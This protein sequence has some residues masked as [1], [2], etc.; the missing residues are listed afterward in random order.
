M[1]APSRSLS[2]TK[3]RASDTKEK[4]FASS[5]VRRRR[6]QHKEDV[7]SKANYIFFTRLNF[8]LQ[9]L[10][11]HFQLMS[12]RVSGDVRRQ[13]DVQGAGN[14]GGWKL[15]LNSLKLVKKN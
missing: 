13:S 8:L 9:Q 7:M 15:F 10:Y 6:P 2:R 12:R 14:L 5:K 1:F 4:L 3:G 11:V